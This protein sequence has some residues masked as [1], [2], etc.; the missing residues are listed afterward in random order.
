MD[1]SVSVLLLTQGSFLLQRLRSCFLDNCL[2]LTELLSGRWGGVR[3]REDGGLGSGVETM[4]EAYSARQVDDSVAQSGQREDRCSY[5]GM[6]FICR[7][8]SFKTG[9]LGA[10][11][12]SRTPSSLPANVLVANVGLKKNFLYFPVS[13]SRGLPLARASG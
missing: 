12:C 4:V 7:D 9:I 5:L 1:F 6:I 11:I 3:L 8:K 10:E 13:L 2:L